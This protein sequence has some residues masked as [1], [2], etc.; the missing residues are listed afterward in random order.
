MRSAEIEMCTLVEVSV[1][2]EEEYTMENGE[3]DRDLLGK[4]WLLNLSSLVNI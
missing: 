3:I 4:M 2:T 1:S